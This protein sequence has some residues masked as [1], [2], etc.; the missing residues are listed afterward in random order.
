MGN[1]LVRH[2]TVFGIPA[3]NWMPV[4]LAIMLVAILVSWWFQLQAAANRF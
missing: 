1:W 2:Y 4:A 3:Q